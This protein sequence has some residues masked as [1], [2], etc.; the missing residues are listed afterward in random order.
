M[1]GNQYPKSYGAQQQMI[2][3]SAYI[4]A[5]MLLLTF[6]A[7]AWAASV[8]EEVRV[9]RQVMGE[10]RSL[11][12]VADPA[13][14]EIGQRLSGVV[15]RQDLPWHFWVIEDWRTYN[16]F[17][18]PGGFVFITRTY[19]EKLNED[20]AAFVLGHEIAHIDLDHY[21]RNVKRLQEANL[22]H[23]LLNVLIGGQASGAWRTA[24]DLGATAYMTHYSR[25]LEK[26]ADVAGYGYAQAA[27]YDARLAVT[28]LSKLGEQP[29]MHPWIVNIYGTHPLITSREDRLAALDGE[30]PD[31]IEIP[32]PSP[33][34]KRDLTQGLKP[35]DPQ[36]RI[37]VRI[38]APDG[39][40]W[41]NAWRKNFTKRLHLRLTPLGF[42][43][44]GDDLMYKPD[45]GDPVEA[46]RSRE[47]DVL[48]LVTVSKMSSTDTGPADLSGT[49]VRGAVEVGAEVLDVA[50]GSQVW[51]GH[52][53]EEGEGRDV[54]AVDAEILYTDTCLGALVEKVAAQIAL[55]CA[56]AAG[57]EPAQ[58][59]GDA[60]SP[61]APAPADSESVA[62]AGEQEPPPVE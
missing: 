49:A 41:E 5:S 47:A 35:L 38:L 54:L 3:R 15:A 50:D 7:R 32:P 29:E 23:L 31:D 59:D 55:G 58:S 26:E 42:V 4:L 48:L 21:E 44:A 16:A 52:F 22:G 12:L 40:R 11:G 9:G 51:G 6:A 10:V 37:A 56:G 53:R 14:Q 62:D 45:I 1:P 27:G 36:P 2:R 43:I 24:T 61:A 33:R 19:F 8:E 13:L 60:T 25:A 17:A 20:E 34:H 46:A 39:G 30:E 18:A 57:A 28:A